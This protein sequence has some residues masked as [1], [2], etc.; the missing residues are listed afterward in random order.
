MKKKLSKYQIAGKYPRATLDDIV[1]TY[2]PSEQFLNKDYL[3]QKQVDPNSQPLNLPEVRRKNVMNWDVSPTFQALNAIAFGTGAVAGTINEYKNRNEERRK[4]I[5]ALQN[6]YDTNDA[7]QNDLPMYTKYGGSLDKYPFGG[8]PLTSEGAKEILKDGTIRGKKITDKQR[9]YF[10]YIAGGGTPHA[11]YG[12]E[13]NPEHKGELTRKAKNAGMSPLE[14]ASHVMANKDKYD[15]ETIKQANFAHN[16]NKQYG[17]D[18]QETGGLP[19]RK[20]A[21]IEAEGGEVYQQPDGNVIKISDSAPSHEQGGVPINNVERVL[22]DTST[23]RKDEESQALRLT[24]LQV[25]T[26]FGIKPKK[27][28]SHSETL[29]FANNDMENKRKSAFRKFNQTLETLDENSND[30]YA[31]NSLDM[32]SDY[33]SKLPKKEDAFEI[34]FNHQENIKQ[35]MDIKNGKAKYGID[36]SKAAYGYGDGNLPITLRNPDKGGG[37]TPTGRN[38]N[39]YNFN[40]PQLEAMAKQFGLRYDN[41]KNFQSDLYDK[42]LTLP[43]GQKIIDQ[44]WKGDATMKGFGNTNQGARLK[45]NMNKAAFV[46]GDPKARTMFLAGKLSEYDPNPIPDIKIPSL[47]L[48]PDN[49]VLTPPVEDKTAPTI[50]ATPSSPQQPFT[51]KKTEPSTFNEPMHWEDIAGEMLGLLDNGRIPTTLNPVEF[52]KVTPKLVNPLPALQSGQRDFNAIASKL[53]STGAGMSNVANLFSQKYST[54]NQVIG[55]YDNTNN[56][57]ENQARYY[58]AGVSDRQSGADAQARDTFERKQLGSMEAQRQQKMT[59]LD[60]IFS[61]IA[62][63]RALNRNGNLIQQLAPNFNSYGQFNGNQRYFTTNTDS[64]PA[65]AGIQYV[66]D[67]NSGQRYRVML[68]PDGKLISSSKVIQDKTAVGARSK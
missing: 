22:E 41:N 11:K 55:Q 63:N 20:G 3:N 13:I 38:N 23:T 6:P 36:L 60:S 62:Q 37:R 5:Q 31:S 29:E 30:K 15:T 68:G 12:V 58:N 64:S 33:I 67:P 16:F 54:D 26:L 27:S 2:N 57:I 40:G 44:M 39:D 47:N 34:L 14:F 61:K 17:G 56:Q 43:D 9:R 25:K 65:G 10:G 59:Y 45:Q 53:P 32:N 46:D 50:P 4:Y 66:T 42:I 18:L 24:P 35:E 8:G 51:L 21:T 19:N 49:D 1:Q 28:L 52:N 7:V 48:P